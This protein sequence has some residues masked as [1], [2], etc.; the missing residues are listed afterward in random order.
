M[1]RFIYEVYDWLR[2]NIYYRAFPRARYSAFAPER[3]A[4]VDVAQLEQQIADRDATILRQAKR[5]DRKEWELA[6]CRRDLAARVGELEAAMVK[7]AQAC[8]CRDNAERRRLE[9]EADIKELLGQRED[10]AAQIEALKHQLAE[11]RATI[12]GV[13]L[14]NAA[15]ERALESAHRDREDATKLAGQITSHLPKVPWQRDGA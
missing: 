8:T 7:Y 4:R 13:G 9:A 14:A 15:L 5:L 10:Q 11:A 1:K 12:E 2:S 3:Q 6:E